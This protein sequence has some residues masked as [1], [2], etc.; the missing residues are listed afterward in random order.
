VS[1]GVLAQAAAYGCAYAAVMLVL[2]IIIFS[3]RDFR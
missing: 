3:R 2:S 1:A